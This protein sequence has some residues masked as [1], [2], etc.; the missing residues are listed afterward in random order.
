MP[1]H[2]IEMSGLPY[3]SFGHA[4]A[5]TKPTHA[6]EQRVDRDEPMRRS[7]APSVEPGLK[8]IHPNTSTSVPI[9]T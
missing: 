7:V 8:P 2:D 4:I 5:M 9:T 1:L 3:L 6:G